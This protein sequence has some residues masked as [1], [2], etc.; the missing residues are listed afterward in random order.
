MRCELCYPAGLLADS[1][2]NTDLG[3]TTMLASFEIVE[4]KRVQALNEMAI[5]RELIRCPK[6][7][8]PD[9]GCSTGSIPGK[10]R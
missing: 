4:I 5:K 2:D 3:D 1:F 7:A 10:V 9:L 8:K 6:V